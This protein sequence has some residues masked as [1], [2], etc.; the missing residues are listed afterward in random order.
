MANF[1][2]LLLLLPSVAFAFMGFFAVDDFVSML[3]LTAQPIAT[4][5]LAVL[6]FGACVLFSVAGFAGAF[7]G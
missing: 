7:A 6:F 3:G 5:S 1:A 4:F 2:A